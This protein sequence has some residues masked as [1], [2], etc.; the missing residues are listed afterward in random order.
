MCF[1]FVA[2]KQLAGH[3]TPDDWTFAGALTGAIDWELFAMSIC[4]LTNLS[5]EFKFEDGIFQGVGMNQ[6]NLPVDAV[7]SGC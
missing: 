4:F 7:S 1:V 6:D 2:L 3:K 5:G